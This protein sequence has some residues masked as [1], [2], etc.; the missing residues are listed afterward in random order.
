MSHRI[1]PSSAA[2]PPAQ[3]DADHTA[4][5]NTDGNLKTV[6]PAYVIPAVASALSRVLMKASCAGSANR[7]LGDQ[8]L[9][10]KS[11]TPAA[12]HANRHSAIMAGNGQ[13]TGVSTRGMGRRRSVGFMCF[14]F[15]GSTRCLSVAWRHGRTAMKHHRMLCIGLPLAPERIADRRA[16]IPSRVSMSAKAS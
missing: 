4:S 12:P 6:H 1:V 13:R 8:S 14:P 5:L 10:L 11:T 2:V 15:G 7:A 9:R 16:R 3:D